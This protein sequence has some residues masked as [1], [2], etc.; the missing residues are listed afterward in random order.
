M[1]ARIAEGGIIL[2]Y[3][4]S[5]CRHVFKRS[6]TPDICPDCGG[7]NIRHA[8]SEELAEYERNQLEFSRPE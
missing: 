2:V 8:T 1:R 7:V 6:E 3:V 4:C 5:K